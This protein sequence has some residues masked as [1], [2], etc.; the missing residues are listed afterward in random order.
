MSICLSS[1]LAYY[2][3]PSLKLFYLS[4]SD[5][6]LSDCRKHHFGILISFFPLCLFCG[7]IA[8][9]SRKVLMKKN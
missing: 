9:P 2:D 3:P 5:F 1:F 4:S 6:F 8:T 7:L